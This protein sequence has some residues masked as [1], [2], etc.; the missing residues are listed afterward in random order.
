MTDKETNFC[1]EYLIDFNATQ[2]AIRAGYSEKSARQIGSENLTKPYIKEYIELEKK[3]VLG[4]IDSI[5]VRIINEL[6]K[7]SF[8][9][10]KELTGHDHKDK[11]KAL[12]LLGKY[13]GMYTDKVEHIGDMSININ[14]VPVGKK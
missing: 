11:L 13:A 10:V 14:V 8:D 9:E 12:D 7:L 6:K 2:A 4:D 3:K 1:H 5:R